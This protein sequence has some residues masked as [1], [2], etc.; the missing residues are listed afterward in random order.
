KTAFD[1]LEHTKDFL[2][3]I[4]FDLLGEMISALA[5]GIINHVKEIWTNGRIP[6]R[7]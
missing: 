3:R 5:D 2:R 6:T 1:F 4:V 7:V